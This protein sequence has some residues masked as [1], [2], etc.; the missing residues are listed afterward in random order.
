MLTDMYLG[1]SYSLGGGWADNELF[2]TKACKARNL[3]WEEG[4]KPILH[5]GYPAEAA[6]WAVGYRTLGGPGYEKEAGIVTD[7]R[8]FVD[9]FIWF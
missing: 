2:F 7:L 5:E 6:D 4:A 3:P 9:A 1:S 8:V